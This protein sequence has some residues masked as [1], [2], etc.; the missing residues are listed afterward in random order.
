M[1]K[2]RCR[3]LTVIGLLFVISTLSLGFVRSVQSDVAVHP[4]EDSEIY[5]PLVVGADSSVVHVTATPSPTATT[6]SRATDIPYPILFVSQ[7]PIRADFTT[8]G[9]TFG[10]HLATMDAVGR[11]GDLW[12]RYPDG[13]LKNLTAAAGYGSMNPGG[14]QGA[15]AIAV[16]DPAVH[17]NGQK[18]IFSM[19]IGAPTKRYEVNAYTW[20]L[21]EITGLTQGETPVITKVL[22]QPEN[23]NNISPVYG[24]DNR[25]IFTT[26]RPRNGASHLYPQLDEY[27][28]APTNT[29]LWSLDPATGDLTLLNHAPSG[30]FTPIID[31]FGRLLFTQ[32]DHLQRDQQADADNATPDGQEL[33][34]G[35]FNYADESANAAILDDRSEVFPE[36]RRNNPDLAQDEVGLRFNHFFPWQINEDGTESEILNHLGRHE[37]HDYFDRSLNTDQNLIEFIPDGSRT[38]QNSIENMFHIEEDPGK[39]GDYYGIDAPEFNTHSSGRIVH[40]SAPPIQ[41]AD[42]IT[43]TYITHPDTI[44][45]RATPNHSGHYREPLPLSDGTLIAVHTAQTA[46]EA[47]SGPSIYDFRLKK[48]H[49]NDDG[50]W[51][52]GEPL[53]SSISKTISYWSPDDLITYSGL[54]WE[55]NPVEVRPRTVAPTGVAGILAL[56]EQ[57]AF[58]EANVAVDELRDFLVENNLALAVSRNVT[59]RDA[60]DRQQ[61]FNLRVVSGTQT[62]ATD[63]TIYDLV[64]LQFFQAD[65]IRGWKAGG[66][67]PRPGRRVLAQPMHDTAAQAANPPTTGPMGSVTIAKDGSIAAFVPA[68]RAMSWQLVDQGGKAIVRERYWITFQ[69]GEIRICT[70]CH[71]VNRKDQAG[72]EPAANSPA[73]LIELL[74]HWQNSREG[75][76]AKGGS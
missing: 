2:N 13:T 56:P 9:S 22:N 12:I 76:S 24:S 40:I 16:R 25:I 69:P 6:A 48:L 65:Q 8:I 38:N 75:I 18:A 15:D 27:E 72:R 49:Q 37:L 34:Y 42:N 32:W 73:A 4:E 55:L 20:Q 57:Q 10:N 43:V 47:T 62:I 17:W 58:A 33:P 64:Y 67:T 30:N 53:T 74:T 35:T 70:S 59:A 45:N 29:G 28:L 11:G 44:G 21:Y 3:F 5:L 50:Y 61:P 26:D 68:N 39:P 19:A 51:R 46:D 66:D 7:L 52:A 31:S 14:F 71:G 54:F 63:G 36:P 23:Y 1:N 41:N 60:H